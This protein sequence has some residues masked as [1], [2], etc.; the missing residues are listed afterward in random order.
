MSS[1][2]STRSGEPPVSHVHIGAGSFGLGMV[3]DI[4]HRRAGFHTTVISRDSDKEY[5][6]CL[7][8][9]GH[10]SIIFD[11]DRATM[12]RLTPPIHWYKDQ[13][14]AQTI[15]LLASPSVTF[16]TTS[17]RK[18]NLPEAA[19]LIAHAIERRAAT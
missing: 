13:D 11:G 6:R 19:P 17:V 9:R 15:S 4:C 3:V 8:E 10:Y 2:A 5:Q 16:V 18:E 12:K 1:T 14:D 7:R